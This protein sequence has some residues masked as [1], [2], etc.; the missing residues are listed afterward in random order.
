MLLGRVI[1]TKKIAVVDT[2]F[3]R[4]DMGR[5][6]L[7]TLS[8]TARQKGWKI[9]IV[10][11]TVPG[12]KDIPVALLQLLEQGCFAGI[13]LGMPGKMPIDKQCAHEASLGIE[14]VQ[15]ITCKSVLEVFVHEDEAAS[16]EEL[17][18][19]M[20]NRTS[21]HAVNILWTLFAPEQL[22][23]RAGTGQRQ[24]KENAKPVGVKPRLFLSLTKG[25]KKLYQKERETGGAV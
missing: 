3:A 5:V 24:G 23:A 20:H 15:L 14:Q 21:K 22:S 12:I 18:R 13:A 8:K 2:M 10:R 25:N 11:A 17:G 19:I 7:E 6:A 1:V 16:D 9:K 4:G